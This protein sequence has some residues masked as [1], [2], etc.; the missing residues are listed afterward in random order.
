MKFEA[1]FE[2]FRSF[3]IILQILSESCTNVS[4]S[5]IFRTLPKIC[6]ENPRM[7]LLKPN[8]DKHDS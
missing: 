1:I 8:E 5:E 2:E 7:F 6:E 4:F 3:R